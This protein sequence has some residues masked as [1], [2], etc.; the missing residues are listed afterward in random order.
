MI[1]AEPKNMLFLTQNK[2]LKQNET[3]R[4]LFYHIKIEELI[5]EALMLIINSQNI[6]KETYSIVE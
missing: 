3:F 1:K 2:P 6:W 5:F 4:P